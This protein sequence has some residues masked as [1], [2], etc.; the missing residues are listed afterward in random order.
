MLLR[1]KRPFNRTMLLGMFL[2]ACAN[3]VRFVLERHTAMPEDPRDAFVGLLYGLAIGSLLLGLW[4][5][6]RDGS[7]RHGNGV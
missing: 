6:N 2:M 5:A 1:R 4:R 7:P 3:V